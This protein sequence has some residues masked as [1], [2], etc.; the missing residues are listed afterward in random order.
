MSRSAQYIGLAPH[1]KKW[2]DQRIQKEKVLIVE[3]KIPLDENGD[4]QIQKMVSDVRLH[5]IKGTLEGKFGYEDIMGIMETK[6]GG[7]LLKDGR[8]VYEKTQVE[9]W[10][11]GP[12]YFTALVDE[13]FNWIEE[14]LWTDKMIDAE[15]SGDAY[16]SDHQYCAK[17]GKSIL[18][19]SNLVDLKLCEECFRINE[20]GLEADC[21]CRYCGKEISGVEAEALMCHSC[22]SDRMLSCEKMADVRRQYDD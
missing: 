9:P 11:S 3:N 22:A 20:L 14:T 8:K 16:V 6:M 4:P 2:L 10:S 13:E 12:M 18:H 19:E 7:F 5:V 17:C 1:A 21:R 15:V